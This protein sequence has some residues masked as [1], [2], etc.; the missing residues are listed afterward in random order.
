MTGRLPALAPDELDEQQRELYDTLVANEVP[1]FE[2]AGVEVRA[3]D[4]SLLGPFNP[5]LFSPAL[6]RAQLEVL[7]AD[8]A[9]T[10][11][12]PRVHEIV[13]L[14]VGAACECGYELYAHRIVGRR[15]GLSEDV[16]EA[17]VAGDTPDLSDKREAT[18]HEFTRQLTREN[19][20]APGTYAAAE[21]M[22]G[23]R[24]VVDIVMLVGLY[25]AT[26]SIINAFEVPSPEPV[27]DQPA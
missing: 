21:R 13:I 6:A 1:A 25:L 26:C 8:G 5:L 16:V 19:R 9:S 15:V 2:A 17:L 14:A 7:R 27:V 23:H 3:W 22:F 10:S 12:S 24:G 4:G 20:V 18:A 11:L